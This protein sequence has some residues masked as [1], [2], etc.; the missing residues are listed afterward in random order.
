M[1]FAEDEDRWNRSDPQLRRQVARRIAYAK[2][3]FM[4]LGKRDDLV[5]VQIGLVGQSDEFDTLVF[6]LF[7][8]LNQAG[9][10]SGAGASPCG[11]TI[12]NHDFSSQFVL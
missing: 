11:E 1:I 9:R 2:G 6:V 7:I 4:I 12:E 5:A 10:S 8:G 3:E